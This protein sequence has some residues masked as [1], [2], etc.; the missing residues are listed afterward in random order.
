MNQPASGH[1]PGTTA[2]PAFLAYRLLYIGFVVLPIA[3]G[4]DKFAQML[5]V[6]EQ[7]L[8]PAVV[9]VLPVTPHHFMLAVGVLEMIAGVIVAFKPRIG[10]FVVA[11]WLCGIIANLLLAGGFYDVALRDLGL[12]LGAVALGLLSREFTA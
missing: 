7:Y 4:L 9:R 1:L 11:A 12:A 3:A 2:R 6:W 10:A 8:A 5:A